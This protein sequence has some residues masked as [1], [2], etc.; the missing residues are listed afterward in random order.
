MFTLWYL[1]YTCAI[2][3]FLKTKTFLIISTERAS[4]HADDERGI[5]QHGSA[6]E[7]ASH[8]VDERITGEDDEERGRRSEEGAAGSE[9]AGRR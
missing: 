5:G 1:S 9:E 3:V 2:V 6:A 7:E 8:E 4:G